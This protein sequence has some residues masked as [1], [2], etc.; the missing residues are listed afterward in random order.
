MS[1]VMARAHVVG[2][3]VVNIIM[4]GPD[5]MVS[6]GYLTDADDAA[7][8]DL[9][10]PDT[11]FSRPPAPAPLPA[12]LIALAADLRWRAEVG[13][14]EWRGWPVHTDRQSQTKVL[15]EHVAVTSGSR[16]DGEPWKFAD[17]LFRELTN[18]DVQDLARA[19]REHVRASFAAEAAVAADIEAGVIVTREAVEAAFA[20]PE[21]DPEPEPEEDPEPEPE[22]DLEPEPEPEPAPEPDINPE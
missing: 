12:E 11:G 6:D 8:G 10:D 21:L 3:I 1:E 17:G 18:A 14:M 4:A 15:A 5:F 7:I 16:L 20:A 19:V 13:G 9:H 2:G 22:E